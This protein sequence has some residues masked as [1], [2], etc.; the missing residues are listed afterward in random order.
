[1][2]HNVTLPLRSCLHTQLRERRGKDGREGE[3]GS[4]SRK[5]EEGYR[6]KVTEREKGKAWVRA[7]ERDRKL[8]LLW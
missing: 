7:G 5:G 2:T 6:I 3:R 8:C 1:M 4:G